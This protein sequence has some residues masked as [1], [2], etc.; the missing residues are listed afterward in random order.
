M[1]LHYSG[2][3]QTLFDRTHFTATELNNFPQCILSFIGVNI[4]TLIRKTFCEKKSKVML[5]LNNIDLTLTFPTDTLA[6]MYRVT[7]SKV[8]FAAIPLC[9]KSRYTLCSLMCCS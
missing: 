4:P 9:R 8:A 7:A 1:I 6:T 3:D 2:S 5:S